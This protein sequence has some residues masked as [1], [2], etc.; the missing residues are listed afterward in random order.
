MI[1]DQILCFQFLCQLTGIL[2]SRMMFLIWFEFICLREQTECFMKKPCAVFGIFLFTFIIWLISTTGQLLSLCVLH[3][4][5]KLFCLC[6]QNIKKCHPVSQNRSIFSVLYFF[7]M[8]FVSDKFRFLWCEKH[9]CHLFQQ[10]D[11]F[12]MSIDSHF[13]VKL[14]SCHSLTIHTKHPYYSKQMINVF[15][16]HK[17]SADFFPAD[18]CVLQ[19]LQNC[20]SATSVYHKIFF[21]FI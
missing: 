16:C 9:L 11:H 2:Y 19:L 13:T 17:Y 10:A 12:I 3:A 15:M 20:I 14:S 5:P 18:S 7:Q 4:E 6:R 21:I 8:D 1:Q